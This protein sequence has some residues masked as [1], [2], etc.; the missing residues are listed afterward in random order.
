MAMLLAMNLNAIIA[1]LLAP[2]SQPSRLNRRVASVYRPIVPLQ[3]AW[4]PNDGRMR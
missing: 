4:I 1:D 2:A 3:P